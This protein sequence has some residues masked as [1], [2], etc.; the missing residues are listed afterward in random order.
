MWLGKQTHESSIC[1]TSLTLSLIQGDR[2]PSR[3]MKYTSTEKRAKAMGPD[4]PARKARKGEE[5]HD[6]PTREAREGEESHDT[7][8]REAR[9]GEESHD[10]P[11]RKSAQRWG[12]TWRTCAWRRGVTWCPDGRILSASRFRR[13]ITAVVYAPTRGVQLGRIA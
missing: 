4:A 8:T 10:T 13:T 2:A 11:A 6:T 12:V 1:T 5:S 3:C 9:E 7:P